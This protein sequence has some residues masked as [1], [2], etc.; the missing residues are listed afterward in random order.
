MAQRRQKASSK[1]RS[2]SPRQRE[3]SARQLLKREREQRKEALERERATS[4]ILRVIAESQTDVQPVFDTIV[5][6]AVKLC[7]GMFANAYRYDGEQLHL[8]A[9]TTKSVELRKILADTYPTRPDERHASGRAILAKATVKVKD[10]VADPA[11]DH[12]F[13]MTGSW[14]RVLAV[15][16]LRSGEP[17][18]VIAVVWANPGP[19]SKRQ[20]QLLQTFA[21]QAVIA[22]EN[23]RLFNETKEA[24]EQQTAISEVLRVIS[25][26]PTDVQPVLEAVAARAA[27]I[28]DAT[29]ARIFLVEDQSVRHAAGFG[30]VPKTLDA[31]LNRGSAIGR[32]VIDRAPVHVEDM[33]AQSD[34]EY[35]WGRRIARQ[36]GWRTVLAVPLLRESRSLGAIVL[37]RIEVR[38]FTEKQIALLKTFADQAAIAIENVRLFNETREAL[39]QQTASSEILRVISSSPTDLRP[40]FDA[41]LESATRLCDAHLGVLNLF[42]GENCRTVAQRGGSPEFAKWVLERGPF[43]PAAAM[44]RV[45]ADR[46]PFHVPDAR[47][48]PGFKARNANAMKFV[49]LGGVRTYVAVPLLKE[50]AVIG[51]INIFRPEIRPFTDKQI[52]LVSTFADQAV[53]AI[54]NVRLFKELQERTEALTKSVGQLTALGE[55]GQAISSTL[56]LETVLKTIVQRAVQL[57]GLDGGSIYEFDERDERFHLRAAE[58]V[59]EEILEMSRRSPIRLGEGAVGRAGAIR[60]P[61]VVEDVL[62]KSYQSRAREL[63]IK[64]GSRALLAVPL[65]HE[66]QIVGA[67]AVQRN[68]PGPFAPEV[69]DLLKT[70]AT[71]SAL[72]IQNAKLFREIRE[73]SAELEVANK[74]L[75]VANKHKSDFLA[76]MSHELRTPLNA[77]IGFSEALMDRMFGDLNEKQLDYQ[78]DIHE[79]G[80]HLL[81]LINDI[82]DLSKIEAG[83]MELELSNFHLPT[84][85]SNAVTLIRERAMRHGIALGVDIDERLGD[86]Q[87]DERKVKQVL[88]NLLSNAVKFTPDGGRVDVSAKLDSDKVEIAVKDTGVGIAPEDQAS[89][90][91]EFKQ[92]GK[93]SS[94]K[95]E[96]TGLGLALTK[97]LVE[98]HGGQIAVE[99]AVG[100]GSIFQVSL[101]LRH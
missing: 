54:E 19:V 15:P 12:R 6:N 97:R 41:I 89:L 100:Q 87:A 101:P 34:D 46:R 17:I 68:T 8:V 92:L 20:E 73:K 2:Q 3:V 88:L 94:R 99:S 27:R 39:E 38:P 7:G 43:K 84:A 35:P 86:F 23:V 42:E 61:V 81:S 37:R 36:I 59:E 49:E 75:E 44:A 18:G 16:M 95:A 58:H 45:L 24:L 5:R 4:E 32:A 71:Q 80:K 13:A 78:K 83:R 40:V 31:P 22:I 57:A 62:D 72:A 55:V 70:F 90:F 52:A 79:S 56:D 30:D 67:L 85:V 66:E 69:V 96:G 91:E 11:Y 33:Q 10:A 26:S 74:Q 76:N 28:C 60:E 47:E 48:G 21:A 77:I 25:D 1:P 93:D 64:T 51:S 98:L 29:D 82:L 53:I 50:G 9:T 63:L 14:R 65:M